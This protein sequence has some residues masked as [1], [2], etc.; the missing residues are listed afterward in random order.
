M[1]IGIP[2]E[3]AVGNGHDLHAVDSGR[4][5]QDLIGSVILDQSGLPILGQHVNPVILFQ[6]GIHVHKNMSI[7][8]PVSSQ[9]G[10]QCITLE[11]DQGFFVLR[12][13]ICAD[14]RARAVFRERDRIQT[15]RLAEEVGGN[16]LN[17]LANDHRDTV[18]GKSHVLEYHLAGHKVLHGD[19]VEVYFI[20]F[21][22]IPEG[23]C[24]YFG[25][26]FG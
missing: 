11:Q 13:G 7:S 1:N 8:I 3:H 14:L 19:C 26:V 15:G 22:A 4:Q 2:A 25:Q 23:A 21:S 5:V 12:E 6:N 10:R 18:S 24:T 20:Q 16:S 9:R 17:R